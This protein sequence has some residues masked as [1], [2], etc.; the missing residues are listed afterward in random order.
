[1]TLRVGYTRKSYN[2][3]AGVHV[4]HA[5]VAP[6]CIKT[7]GKSGV[8]VISLDPDDHFLSEF[9][10]YDVENKTQEERY[11]ALHKLIAHFEPIKG[12]Q[13][14]WNYI[15]RALNARYILNR[16]TNPKIARIMKD[17]QRAISKEYKK[18]KKDM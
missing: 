15:I 17:D 14:T 3:K 4:R 13:A 18:I 8:R 5:L 11:H 9:G 12:K 1:M 16:N 2:R 7:R 10:Y 6:G